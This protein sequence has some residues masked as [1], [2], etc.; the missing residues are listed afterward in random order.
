M[1][2]FSGGNFVRKIIYFL[3]DWLL[4]KD[5]AFCPSICRRV[6]MASDISERV[7]DGGGG[8]MGEETKR[9]MWTFVDLDHASAH[10]LLAPLMHVETHQGLDKVMGPA[11]KFVGRIRR[12][13]NKKRKGEGSDMMQL[14]L[15]LFLMMPMLM[16]TL[17]L[18]DFK[19]GRE[20]NKSLNFFY[21][22]NM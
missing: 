4:Q 10:S 7:I 19:A 11:Y 15:L 3:F 6:W 21:L 14:V 8:G 16:R 18:W 5:R 17:V 20:R 1:Y 12:K 13:R 22:Y 2:Y 9:K